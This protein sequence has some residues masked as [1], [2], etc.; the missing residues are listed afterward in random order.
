MAKPRDDK[1]IFDRSF[2]QIISSISPNALIH[3]INALFGSNHPFDSE[4]RRLN[5]EHIDKSLKKLQPD[6]IISVGG[7]TYII[8]EQTTDD[9]N[10]AIRLFEYGYAQALKDRKTKDGIIMLTFPR[11]VVI[12]LEAGAST[13]DVLTARMKFPDGMEYDFNVKTV[14]LFDY[15][16]EELLERGLTVLLPFY[17]IRLRKAARQ[18]KTDDEKRGVEEGFKELGLKLKE[19]IECGKDNGQFEEE[20]IVT[21]LERL[22]DLLNYVGRGYRT[23]EVKK[24]LK[25]S[26]MGYGQVLALK[27][28]RQG[29]RLGKRLG[30][31]RGKRLGKLEDARNALNEGLSME[32][33][34]RITGIPADELLKQLKRNSEKQ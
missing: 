19:A 31:R 24:M 16:V 5:T 34:E 22:S 25:T 18:A 9:A 32:Q 12:Y 8:E 3:F 20:D 29:K 7:S 23:T 26:L 33:V 13:P 1:D 15:S 4:V 14:K 11:M 17:I 21:L 2:K 10:M 28:K 27:Y 30:E 6:E